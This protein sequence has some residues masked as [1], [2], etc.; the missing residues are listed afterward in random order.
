MNLLKSV[1]GFGGRIG[2]K[3]YAANWLLITLASVVLAFSLSF[4]AGVVKGLF[5]L[6]VE[7]NT[8]ARVAVVMGAIF[9]IFFNANNCAKRFRDAYPNEPEPSWGF[10][11]LMV[12]P[13]VCEFVML[14]LLFIPG[15]ICTKEEMRQIILS[16]KGLESSV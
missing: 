2:R 4:G 5:L 14:F 3:K 13:A 9:Y 12:L 1:F 7:I 6:D 15:D 10:A 16:E 8:L 11:L